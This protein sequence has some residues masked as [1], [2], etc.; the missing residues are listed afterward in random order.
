MQTEAERYAHV[1]EKSGLNKKDFADSLGLRKEQGS[2]LSRGTYRAT[3]EVLSNL[4]LRYNVDLHWYLTGEGSPEAGPGSVSVALYEQEAAA[5]RG[6][7]IE[8]YQKKTMVPV[9]GDLLRPWKPS[10]VRAVYV[11]GDS[12]INAGINDR[13]IILFRICQREGNGIY[14][15]SIGSTLLVK[16]VQFDDLTETVILI[17]ENPAYPPREISGD[18]LENLKIEG[19]VIACLHRF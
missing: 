17:S 8:E 12:M 15:L 13:D 5:G 1:Q 3:R 7:E 10:S 4:A 9:P 11:S 6:R 18:D 14:V 2:M 19:R 16:R